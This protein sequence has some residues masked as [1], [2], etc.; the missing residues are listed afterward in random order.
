MG[1]ILN[2]PTVPKGLPCRMAALLKDWKDTRDGMKKR[3]EEE[4][5]MAVE[6]CAEMVHDELTAFFNDMKAW[7]GLTPEERTLAINAAKLTQAKDPDSD[8]EDREGR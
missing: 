3:G 1:E 4:G 5:A 8:T 6:V 7:Q 2:I